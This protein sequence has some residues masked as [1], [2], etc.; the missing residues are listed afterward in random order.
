MGERVAI[1]GSRDW[2]TPEQVRTYVNT[3]PLT[4]VVV[5]GDGGIVD[6][7]AVAAAQSRGLP[8][9]VY[10]ADWRRYGRRA[11]PM[12]NSQIVASC[13]R[14]VAFHDGHSPGTAD[15]IRKAHAAG[16]PVDLVS[17]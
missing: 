17:P 5:S 7:V 15:M 9:L 3:L 16:L 8:T 13:D 4:S 1:V 14:V 12:R 6:R 10:P 11:G 2:A